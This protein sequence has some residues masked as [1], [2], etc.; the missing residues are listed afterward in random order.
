MSFRFYKETW[1]E[2]SDVSVNA[3]QETKLEIGVTQEY[4]VQQGTLILTTRSM[5]T[6]ES[7]PCVVKIKE[8]KY[9]L[10]IYGN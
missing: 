3:N 8:F 10:N 4:M 2:G 7:Y 6:I 9:N 1:R 5:Q